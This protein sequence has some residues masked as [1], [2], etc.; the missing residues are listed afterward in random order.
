[1]QPEQDFL[2]LYGQP[3]PSELS[4]MLSQETNM[5]FLGSAD[6]S[7]ES[8]T[9]S[10]AQ[11][12]PPFPEILESVNHKLTHLFNAT[13]RQLPPEWSMADLVRA[14]NAGDLS[15]LVR[16]FYDLQS[17]GTHSWL[18]EEI[19]NLLDLINYVF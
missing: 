13:E 15:S 19:V 8:L 2:I 9:E 3:S 6:S 11:S 16:D 12:A 1:M 18:W 5:D 10:E 14:V 7:L 4:F 17:N